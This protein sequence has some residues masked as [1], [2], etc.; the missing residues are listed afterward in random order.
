MKKTK[1]RKR[2]ARTAI[3]FAAIMVVAVIIRIVWLRQLAASEIGHELSIDS[4]F[5]R[6]LARDVVSGQSLPAGALTFNPLYPFFLVVVFRLFGE[7]LLATRLVQV[8]LGLVTIGLIYIAGRRLIDGP[9]KGRLS[10]E[11]VAIVAMAMAVLYPQFVLYEGMVLGVTLEIFLLA[12]SFTLALAMDQDLHGEQKLRV[13]SR[14]VPTWLGG[15]LLGAACGAGALGRPNLF[16]PLVAGVPVWFL[17]RNRRTR[18]WIAPVLGFAVGAAIFLLPPTVYNARNTG[19]FVPVTAHGGI[20]FYIGNRPGTVGVYQPPENMRGEMRGLIEDARAKAEAETGRT[21]TD[22]EVSDYYM[23]KALANI[24][25]DPAGWLL[26]IGRK[27]VLFWNKVEVHDMP[28]VVYFQDS[29]PLFKFLF[30]PFSVIGALGLAGFIVFMRSGRNRSVVC[31]FLGT[32]IV[33]VLL[34]YMNSRYRLPIVPV[35]ILLAA[36]FIA[37]AAREISQKR[38]KHVALMI[39]VAAA[40]FFAVS[41]R[42]IVKANRGSVYT[43][44]GTYYMNSGNTAKA[45]EAFAEAYRLDPERD[46]SLIN[47]ARTLLLQNK[48]QRAADLYARAYALNPRYPRLAI[49]YAYALDELGRHEEARN[50]YLEVATSGR[51]DDKVIACKVLA[52][53]AFFAGKKDEAMKWVRAGLAIAP[54]DADLGMMLKTVEAMP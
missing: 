47:Y 3:I 13:G 20:N 6:N 8:L 21:M 51:P 23:E 33:S 12:A 25:H 46:V 15:C 49:E 27:L 1:P 43:F 24:R 14:H 34:F 44:L 48:F 30:L 4:E 26:L 38:L 29:M 19:E 50:I 45:A 31:L 42:N 7:S 32:A 40:L 36:F 39:T 37:W 35:V 53:A 11:V 2:F 16:L 41:N 17:V 28:E 9:R 5:Y 52:Q 54:T 22:A 18:L 10:G